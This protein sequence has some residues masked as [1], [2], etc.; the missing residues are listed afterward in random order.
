MEWQPIETL[1]DGE[2][3]ILLTDGNKVIPADAT[4]YEREDREEWFGGISDLTSWNPSGNDD[5][6]PSWPSHWMPLPAP[7]QNEV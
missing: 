3:L 7:P 4:Y 2:G 6:D 5:V 1:P